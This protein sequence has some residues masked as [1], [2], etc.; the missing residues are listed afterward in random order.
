MKLR[1]G[2]RGQRNRGPLVSVVVPFRD[3]DKFIGEAIESVLAQTYK[4]WELVLVDDGST[5]HST[6]IALAYKER[7]PARVS[8]LE[9][10]GHQNRGVCASRNLGI[11][12]SK[13][14]YIALLDADDVWLPHKLQRQVAILESHPEAVLV[15]GLSQYWKSW[16]GNTEEKHNDSLPELGVHPNRIFRPPLLLTLLYP[17]GKAPAPCPS[18]ILIRR[19]SIERVGGFEESFD[20]QPNYQLYEDQA[21]LAKVYLNFPVFASN[22]CWDRYRLHPDS[23]SSLVTTEGHYY[24]IRLFFL[25]WLK[26]YL[27]QSRINDKQVWEALCREYWLCCHDLWSLQSEY[28]SVNH[29]KEADPRQILWWLR[30]AETNFASLD[31]STD[32]PDKMRVVITRAGTGTAYDIQL[33]QTRLKSKLNHCYVINFLARADNP[34]SIFVGFAK[35]HA[36]WTNLGLHRE[37]KLTRDWQSFEEHFSCTE[38]DENARI[39]FD[40]GGTEMSVEISSVAL[41]SLTDGQFVKPNFQGITALHSS[42]GEHLLE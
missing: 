26:D 28:L 14:E 21:F 10:N 40:L 17:L 11:R 37:I 19:D 4:Q 23:C 35:A 36:P 42:H 13:G 22:E 24:L 12:H 5:D 27:T 34:R 9:H 20:V 6:A 3:T 30:V 29:A 7:D 39:H 1:H 25:N 31:F 16:T 2:D 38:D 18:D 8:Y 15:Y 33:N 32:N 41:R